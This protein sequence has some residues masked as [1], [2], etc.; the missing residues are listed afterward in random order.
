VLDELLLIGGGLFRETAR[1]IYD[2]ADF[3]VDRG[4]GRIEPQDVQE[5][6]NHVRK[7][8]QPMI[9]GDAIEV[10]NSVLESEQGWVP[11]VEPYLQ[12]RAVVEYENAELWLDVRYPL[13]P[14]VR[15]L[16]QRRR[17]DA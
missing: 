15:E 9:R 7:D 6:Y 8:Y 14:Y 4:A 10:L 1:A 11:G 5:V 13:K 2:A 3:A 16:A 17:N 12:S